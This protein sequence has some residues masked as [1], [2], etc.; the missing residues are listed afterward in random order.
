MFF[1]DKIINGILQETYTEDDRISKY[2]DL[3]DA[4]KYELEDSKKQNLNV[5]EAVYYIISHMAT[6][7]SRLKRKTPSN[8]AIPKIENIYFQTRKLLKVASR[9]IKLKKI[10]ND[11]ESENFKMAIMSFNRLRQEPIAGAQDE[12]LDNLTKQINDKILEKTKQ[13]QEFESQKLQKG[14]RKQQPP[15]LSNQQIIQRSLDNIKNKPPKQPREKTLQYI[16]KKTREEITRIAAQ[17]AIDK[18]KNKQPK[19]LK[20]KHQSYRPKLSLQQIIQR[21]LDNINKRRTDSE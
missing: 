1:F 8:P 10:L 4:V 6:E 3:K 14:T 7:I 2:N 16:P 11:L 19:P 18:V 5:P 15:K 17:K 21:S 12:D 9:I 13:K 20:Q